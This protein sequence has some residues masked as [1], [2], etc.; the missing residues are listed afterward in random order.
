[1]ALLVMALPALAVVVSGMDSLKVLIYS[2]VALSIQLPLTILPLVL[3]TSD[4]KVMGIFASGRVE[5]TLAIAGGLAVTV[6]NILFLY[7]LAGGSL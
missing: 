2:Q 1:V 3:L 6:L 7:N 5:K 4:R